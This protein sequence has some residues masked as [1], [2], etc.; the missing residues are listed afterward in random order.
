MTHG[1]VI[2]LFSLRDL[3]M[4]LTPNVLRTCFSVLQADQVRSITDLGEDGC[5]G[6]GSRGVAEVIRLPAVSHDQEMARGSRGLQRD[7]EGSLGAKG[8]AVLIL[9]L[10]MAGVAPGRVRALQGT[11]CEYLS[12][13]GG[14][15]CGSCVASTTGIRNTAWVAFSRPQSKVCGDTMS[16]CDVQAIVMPLACKLVT[17][18]R[19]MSCV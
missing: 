10:P 14:P 19:A 17:V 4:P 16:N 9:G 1:T 7:C 12:G 3:Q 8:D 11:G 15:E 18:K 6:Q 2:Y 13:I 5:K